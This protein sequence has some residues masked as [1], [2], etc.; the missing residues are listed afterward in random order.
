MFIEVEDFIIVVV[1]TS[2]IDG[3]VT[4]I[5]DIAVEMLLG[6]VVLM[7]D[8]KGVVIPVVENSV[9]SRPFHE[10][11]RIAVLSGAVVVD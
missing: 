7:V 1:K 5:I 9:V 8:S 2:I 11:G 6:A 10:E 4:V 3:V